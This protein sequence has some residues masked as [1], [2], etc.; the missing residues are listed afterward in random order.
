[1]EFP[2]A[3]SI[4]VAIPLFN[5]ARFLE[6]NGMLPSLL[7]QTMTDFEMVLVDDGSTDNTLQICR[8]LALEDSRIRV[9]TQENRGVSVARN[10]GI[11]AARGQ[12]IWIVD[13]DDQLE[14]NALE[15][16]LEA[17]K[18][19]G[20]DIIRCNF[21]IL[22]GRK[23]SINH[24]MHTS[25]FLFDRKYIRNEIIS[26]M[27]GVDPDL[28]KQLLGHWTYVIRRENL[29]TNGV[30]YDESKRKE[31]DHRFSV[32]VLDAANSLV[33]VQDALYIHIR[34]EG[35][36]TSTYTPRFDNIMDN[37]NHYEELFANEFDFAGQDKL[38]YN[39]S[40]VQECAQYVLQHERE[41]GDKRHEI[42]K[43][44]SHPSVLDWYSRLEP[45]EA[46]PT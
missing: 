24:S 22:N 2:E 36:L 23:Q 28:R 14:P 9:V 37:F 17:A 34:R 12:Y 30:F 35:S 3:P 42:E 45:K 46:L 33:I 7:A 27:I 43:I 8:D 29:M 18:K 32:D 13:Q 11:R 15:V 31:D 26:S 4:S 25:G 6:G 39:I 20:P 19:F 44:L 10:M 21:R 40:F 38:A 41:V 5:A 16:I 1:M